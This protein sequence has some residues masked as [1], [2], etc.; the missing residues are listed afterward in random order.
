VHTMEERGLT[1]KL[2]VSLSSLEGPSN[3][4]A[5]RLSAE[6][7][8]APVELELSFAQIQSPDPRKPRRP[9]RFAPWIYDGD[10]ARPAFD[11]PPP[12]VSSR[13]AE[14]AESEYDIDAWA[15]RAQTLGRELGPARASELVGAMVHPPPVPDGFEAPTWVARAQIACALGLAGVDQGWE[16]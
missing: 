8:G 6:R 11:P 14:I 16:G 15:E 7:R 2:T 12:D 3:G 1:G 9:S 5:I 13:V 10:E 4:V